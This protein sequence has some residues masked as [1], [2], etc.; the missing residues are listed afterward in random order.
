MSEID[1][2]TFYVRFC[3]KVPWNALFVAKGTFSDV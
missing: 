3:G 1:M 2:S